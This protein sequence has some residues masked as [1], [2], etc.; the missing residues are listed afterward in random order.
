MKHT[1]EQIIA[2][3]KQVMLDIEW[4][5]DETTSPDGAVYTS[6]EQQIAEMSRPPGAIDHPQFQIVVNRLYPYWTVAFDFPEEYDWKGRNVMFLDIHA[7]KPF[8]A[9]L[10][11]HFIPQH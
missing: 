11:R 9:V 8:E 3:A 5:Y 4:T 6:V 1:E 10:N 7:Q 2:I